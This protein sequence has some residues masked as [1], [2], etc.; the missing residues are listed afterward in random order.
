MW[1][2]LPCSLL[3]LSFLLLISVIERKQQHVALDYGH[4]RVRTDLRIYSRHRR[5]VFQFV[6]TILQVRQ[7]DFVLRI[8]S[9]EFVSVLRED[10]LD[11]FAENLSIVGI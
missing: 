2:V 8:A 1:L 6:Q 5:G 4:A 11:L 9:V 3:V 7:I 10:I